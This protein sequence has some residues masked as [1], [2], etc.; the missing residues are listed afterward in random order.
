MLVGIVFMIFGRIKKQMQLYE[1]QMN[2]N[3]NP[4]QI[5]IYN[6]NFFQWIV[7]QIS[8]IL[9]GKPLLL[10]R[11]DLFNICNITILLS[12]YQNSEF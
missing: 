2:S 7:Q 5:F 6:F 1:F 9:H 10:F 12:P 3:Q 11:L 4:Y 8:W